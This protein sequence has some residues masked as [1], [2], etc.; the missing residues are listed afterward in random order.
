MVAE[1]ADGLGRRH[2]PEEDGAVAARGGEA[3]VVRGDGEREDLVG[4]GLVG[5][6]EAAF[7]EGVGRVFGLLLLLLLFGDVGVG[8][9]DGGGGLGVVQPDGAV[10]AAG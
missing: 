8:R 5:L 4:V 1:A 7:R 2:V 9:V 10:G 3:G 6:D